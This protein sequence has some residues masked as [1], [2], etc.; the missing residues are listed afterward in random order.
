MVTVK[1]LFIKEINKTINVEIFDGINFLEGKNG[2]GKTMLLDH[3]SSLRP[4]P[5]NA[6]IEISNPIYMRQDFTFY[7]RLTVKEF[8]TFIKELE[9][10]TL[11][12]FFQFL[13]KYAFDAD[14]D[15]ILNTK[16]GM[17]SG[18]ERRRVYLLAI[19][20]VDKDWY[21]L[22]EPF[23]NLDKQTTESFNNLIIEMNSKDNKNFIITSHIDL[24]GKCNI[25]DFEKIIN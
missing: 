21:L 5:K 1:N 18:G 19:L 7:Y 2:S 8:L 12:D 23:A 13:N 11:D 15:N 4:S 6:T 25:V 10:K 17:L 20:S 9:N 24:Q 16:L 14:L 22:D 3:L